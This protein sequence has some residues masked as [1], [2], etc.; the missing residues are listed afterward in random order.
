MKVLITDLVDEILIQGL[1]E[2]GFECDYFPDFKQ[3]ELED[4]ISAYTGIIITTK[5]SI[6]Q[7]HLD[8]STQLKFIAR[9]GSGLDHVDVSYAT[10]K[11]IQIYTSPEANA[12]C[13]GEH[14]VGMMI[15][16]LH[17]FKTSN[18]D[19]MQGY[20]RSEPHRVIELSG[21]T[22]GIL[23]YGNTGPAFAKRLQ[24]FDMRVLAYDKYKHILDTYCTQVDLE[25]LQKES[26]IISIHLPLTHETR[27]MINMQFMQACQR[28]HY[29]I[30]TSRGYILN[31]ID[32]LSLLESGKLKGVAL[33][34]I[35]NE[36]IATFTEQEKKIF[37][38]LSLHPNVLITPHIAG[39]SHSS[40][41]QHAKVILK[42]IIGK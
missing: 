33:D 2:H 17:H 19:V 11:G 28:L 4:V 36:N 20:F 30:N 14:A 41:F 29:I 22:V 21:L 18:A 25:T 40:R 12:S 15:H 26:D 5:I 23:G 16:M 8:K 6:Q 37:T 10:S 39:K 34:V 9:L 31:L 13:V 38:A 35:D 27:D 42:K 24:G 3:E 1:R 7:K 32:T